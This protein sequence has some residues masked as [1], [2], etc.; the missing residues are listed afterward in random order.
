M[1]WVSGDALAFPQW[2]LPV[3]GF[4]ELAQQAQAICILWFAVLGEDWLRN[5]SIDV[6][7]S[8]KGITLNK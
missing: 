8:K 5:L 4:A 7:K 3:L 1:C 2:V 6:D